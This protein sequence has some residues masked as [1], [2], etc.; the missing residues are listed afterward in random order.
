MCVAEFQGEGARQ[1]GGVHNDDG[2]GALD[3]PQVCQGQTDPADA[4]GQVR[5]ARCL[6]EQGHAAGD[7]L[8]DEDQPRGRATGLPR[9]TP[10]WGKRTLTLKLI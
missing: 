10:H 2:G 4:A 1:V 8:E 7:P 9:R 5:G 3:L 6:H